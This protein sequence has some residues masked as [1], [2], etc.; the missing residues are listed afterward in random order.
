MKSSSRMRSLRLGEQV[1]STQLIEVRPS[2]LLA[3]VTLGPLRPA[4]VLD[5][6]GMA[7]KI[8]KP[9][10]KELF[11]PTLGYDLSNFVADPLVKLGCSRSR[12][13]PQFKL[14]HAASLQGLGQTAAPDIEDEL[15]KRDALMGW[16][17]PCVYCG[18]AAKLVMMGKPVCQACS[19]MLSNG[20]LDP[21][22]PTSTKKRTILRPG[23]IPVLR[24]R[25]ETIV[26][27]RPQNRFK[28]PA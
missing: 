24:H 9:T 20:K 5:R 17:L 25:S 13:L 8:Q 12:V 1:S 4:C 18:M 14:T 6:N 11:G 22:S 3:R 28:E 15:K 10:S 23:S 2:Y 26:S 7:R 27:V 21:R 19:D 16:E